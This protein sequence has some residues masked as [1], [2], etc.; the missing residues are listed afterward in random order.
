MTSARIRCT[1][2]V[3]KLHFSHV[4]TRLHVIVEGDFLRSREECLG[5]VREGPARLDVSQLVIRHQV[6]DHTPQKGRLRL[7]VRVKY[8]HKVAEV[9][10]KGARDETDAGRREE[11]GPRM[12]LGGGPRGT[13]W[14]LPLRDVDEALLQSACLVSTAICSAFDLNLNAVQI[15]PETDAVVDAHSRIL[16]GRIVQHLRETMRGRFDCK[17]K[18]AFEV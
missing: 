8:C 12:P 5:R 17:N 7:E 10:E 11:W 13:F 1:W 4:P 14:P 3:F 2:L 9:E 6:R 18:W 15:P 16:L